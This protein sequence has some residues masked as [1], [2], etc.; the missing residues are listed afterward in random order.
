MTEPSRLIRDRQKPTPETKDC[1]ILSGLWFIIFN[2]LS[3]NVVKD[4]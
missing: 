1:V 2:F 4:A 3:I